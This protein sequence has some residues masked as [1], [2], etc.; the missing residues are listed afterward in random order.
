MP[1]EVTEPIWDA[2]RL[3]NPHLSGDKQRRVREMFAAIAP[4]YDLNNRLWSLGIDQRWRRKAVKLSRL[5]A[6]DRVVDVA[7]GTG[8]LSVMF[9]NKLYPD[10]VDLY[11]TARVIGID[12]TFPMLPRAVR[13]WSSDG[14]VEHQREDPETNV[15]AAEFVKFLH[16]DAQ[17]LPLPDACCDVVSI[18]FGIRNVADSERAYREFRRV[19]RPG[20]RV[21]VLEF[22]KPTN[23]II[24]FGYNLYFNHVLTRLAALV[25]R[26]RTG[27]YRYL[28]SSVETF[29]PRARMRSGV[30][31]GGVR[32]GR[33][34]PAD[35]RRGGDLRRVR[36]RRTPLSRERSERYRRA[37]VA[38]APLAAHQARSA[39]HTRFG[40]GCQ[41]QTSSLAAEVGQVLAVD[42]LR[43]DVLAEE[44]DF[45]AAFDAPDGPFDGI[46]RPVRAVAAGQSPPAPASPP[47]PTP[48][49]RR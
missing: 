19:L 24:R 44:V 25:A 1:S 40:S 33:D 22:S 43:A 10:A 36:Q 9:A 35:V 34:A 49:G 28:A 5:A 6:G 17:N 21:V 27:A 13:K 26:D 18:A 4:A 16:G 11:G 3:K 29:K 42:L 46:E 37:P 14:I 47:R 23:R 41:F 39:C 12:Y 31:G 8:D 32:A 48:A 30:G 20:G 15:G 38:L 2:E 7:C 45:A